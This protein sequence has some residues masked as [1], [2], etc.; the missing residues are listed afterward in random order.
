MP[1]PYK[2]LGWAF[3]W[4]NHTGTTQNLNEPRYSDDFTTVREIIYDEWAHYGIYFRVRRT[5]PNVRLLIK[6]ALLQ[7]KKDSVYMSKNGPDIEVDPREPYVEF[8]PAPAYS[9][10]NDEHRVMLFWPSKYSTYHTNGTTQKFQFH[11]GWRPRNGAGDIKPT[12][13][14][15]LPVISF[16]I[17]DV[18]TKSP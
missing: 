16:S 14:N 9:S 17:T 4:N 8:D 18:I 15:P 2:F 7:E 6:G 1:D 10:E 5:D 11:I 3:K 13:A 12:F